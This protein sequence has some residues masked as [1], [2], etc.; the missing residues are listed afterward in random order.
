L[1][2]PPFY[3][4]RIQESRRSSPDC[5]LPQI[6]SYRKP[7]FRF[8]SR[9]RE[10]TP[11]AVSGS[12]HAVFAGHGHFRSRPRFRAGYRP[13]ALRETPIPGCWQASELF[14]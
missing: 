4:G 6:F 10:K 5:I 8:F 13:D 3:F 14:A 1:I 7:E 11:V 12:R 2:K 9:L